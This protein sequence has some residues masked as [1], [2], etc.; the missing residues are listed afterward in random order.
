MLLV[1]YINVGKFILFNYIIDVDVYVVDQL[2]VI[3]DLILCKLDIKEVGLVILVDMVGFICYFFYDLVVVFKVMLQEIQEVE[4]LL[5]VVD[6]FVNNYL[7]IMDE[8]NMVFDE[9]DVG[10]IQ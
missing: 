5:Y 1:G 6:Y 2:F 8:V 7:E 3:L 4:L 10:E 9:I